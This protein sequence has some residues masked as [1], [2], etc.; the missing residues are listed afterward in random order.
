MISPLELCLASCYS[1]KMSCPK[2]LG[3]AGS[4]ESWKC[5][6]REGKKGGRIGE[7]RRGH[8]TRE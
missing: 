8:F 5:R 4:E 7:E 1:H 3:E 2:L 6:E